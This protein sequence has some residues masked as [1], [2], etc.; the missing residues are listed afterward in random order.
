MQKVQAV[1]KTLEKV[2]IRSAQTSEPADRI[3]FY[4]GRLCSEDFSEII[5]LCGNGYGVAGIKLLRGMYEKAVTSAFIAKKP[6]EAELFLDYH[7]IH[8]KKALNHL[9]QV[10][11]ADEMKELISE[12]QMEEIQNEAN[13]VREQ[14][15]EVLCET[16]NLTR[17]RFSWSKL[18]IPDMAKIAGDGYRQLYYP[19]YYRPTLQTHTTVAAILER[20]VMKED[21]S[22]IFNEGAQRQAARE[23]IHLAH[24]LIIQVINTQ[25]DYFSLG[26]EKDIEERVSD[27]QEVWSKKE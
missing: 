26:T 7:L 25:N 23:A 12:S 19:C 10:Y 9:R 6:E 21:G 3:V 15:K 17:D 8:Q 14:F 5:L 2:F 4:L 13:R 22:I 27:F 20:L 11:N 1:Y 16:C 24:N 18:G